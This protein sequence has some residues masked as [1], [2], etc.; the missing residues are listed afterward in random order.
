MIHWA[1]SVFQ[2]YSSLPPLWSTGPVSPQY[3]GLI[4]QATTVALF[5][6]Y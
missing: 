1:S 3:L 5:F 6:A 2:K 4:T